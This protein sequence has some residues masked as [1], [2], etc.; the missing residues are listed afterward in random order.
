MWALLHVSQ[1]SDLWEP[2]RSWVPGTRVLMPLLFGLPVPHVVHQYASSPD[3]GP[4]R[5]APFRLGLVL[6]SL[7]L[8]VTSQ[9]VLAC[10]GCLE[11]HLPTTCYLKCP[12]VSHVVLWSPFVRC[13][14]ASLALFGPL[15]W[16]RPLCHCWCVLREHSPSVHLY[17][18]SGKRIVWYSLIIAQSRILFRFSAYSVERQIFWHSVRFN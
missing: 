17:T 18:T 9:S 5:Y 6:T 13:S 7:M 14:E 11:R 16:L 15:C 1:S 3:P 4:V 10:L 2:W 8:R 12:V